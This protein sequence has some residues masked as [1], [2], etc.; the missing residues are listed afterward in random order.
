MPQYIEVNGQ[1]IEFPDGMATG[2]I[3]AAIKKNMLSIAPPKPSTGQAV[4]QGAGN[5]L[6][7]LTR[8]AGS[9]GATLV[10]PWDIARDAIAGKGLSLESNRQRRADMDAALGELGADTNSWAY[11]GG[12]LVGEVAGTAGVGGAVANVAGRGLGAVAPS[13]LP[14]AQPLLSAIQSGGMSAPGANLLTRTAGGAVT[15]GV[16]AAAVNP[17]DVVSG[18]LAG[19][20]MP[21]AVRALG[22][23]GSAVGRQLRPGGE[24]AQ[25]ARR[26]MD[27]GAPLGIADVAEGKF[28]KAVRS[29]LNDAPLT[30]GIGAAQNDA[31]QKWF[32]RAVGEV[33]DAADDKLTPQVMDAAKQKMGSEFDRIWSNNSLKVDNQLLTTLSKTRANATMLPKAERSRIVSMLDDLEGQ[34][35][36]AADGSMVIPGEVANRYQSSI[37]KASESAQGFLKND[38]TNLRKDVIGAFNRSVSPEDAAALALNQRKYKAF[39]TVEPLLNKGEL[40][41]AGREA[42]DVPAALLPGAVLQ[43]YKSN[44]AGSPLAELSKMGSKYL[45]DRSPQTGGSARALIQNSAIGGALG[46]G[47]FSNPLLAA[48]VIPVGM[49][50]NQVLG[51]PM[52]ARGLLSAQAPQMGGLLSLG[53]KVAPVLTAQ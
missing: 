35:V 46:V 26:A 4:A 16:T 27:M 3:E 37:R 13:L 29:V 20:A 45:V 22:S 43:S 53:Q 52:L 40:G 50:M 39:K 23:V 34:V 21:G 33:F 6:A 30:G 19:A 18:A 25:L 12:K 9:I 7:G 44:P 11:K 15:G 1:T 8:G 31:K 47:M 28:T 10:A 36:Q 24:N 32:N 38:L 49:G 41:V 5:L 14:K 51:S 42:G 48:G 2:D 17:E